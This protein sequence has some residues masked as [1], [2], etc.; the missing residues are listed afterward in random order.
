MLL[1]AAS[2]RLTS[3]R[4]SVF[5]P[6][7]RSTRVQARLI[8]CTDRWRTTPSLAL[9][10]RRPTSAHSLHPSMGRLRVFPNAVEFHPGFLCTPLRAAPVTPPQSAVD[11]RTCPMAVK[12]AHSRF[13][14]QQPPT[15]LR[16]FAISKCVFPA[17]VRILAYRRVHP[18]FEAA[19]SR[20]TP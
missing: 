20:L 7:R 8:A 15:T 16:I 10:H 5:A 17:K 6:S 3:Y 2:F 14:C 9:L 13:A 19:H 1:C 18:P 4:R 11:E 12:V